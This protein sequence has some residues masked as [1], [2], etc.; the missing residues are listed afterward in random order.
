[1]VQIDQVEDRMA[2]SAHHSTPSHE[3]ST[4]S[5]LENVKHSKKFVK[6]QRVVNYSFSEDSDTPSLELLRSQHVQNH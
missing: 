4:D 6:K 1:M 2:A 5:F 3:L